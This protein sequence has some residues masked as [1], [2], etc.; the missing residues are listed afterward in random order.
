L[1]EAGAD[2]AA[3]S[4]VTPHVCITELANASPIPIVNI[5]DVVRAELDSRGLQRI[6]L[7]GTRYVIESELFGSLSGFDVVTPTASETSVIDS[8]YRELA[9]RGHGVPGDRESL[10]RIALDL[11]ERERLDAVVLAGTDLSVL[12]DSEDPAF[13]S[14]DCSLVHIRAIAERL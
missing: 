11:C 3:I 14:V 1:S 13:P 10:S 4:A 2:V 9:L 8:V 12:F 6:A 7:L 5:L